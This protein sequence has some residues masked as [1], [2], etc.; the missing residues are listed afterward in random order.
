MIMSDRSTVELLLTAL[1]SSDF[2]PTE[3]REERLVRHIVDLYLNDQQFADARPSAAIAEPEMRL[4]QI[5]RTVMAGYADRPALGQRAVRFLNDPETGRT[6]LELL[7]R[8]ETVTYRE[9]CD[10][11]GAFANALTGDSEHSVRSGD[12]VC[13][14]GF[15]GVR[16]RDHRHGIDSAG[17]R[18]RSATAP[19]P[20]TQLRPIVAETEPVVIAAGADYLGDA[21]E[22]ILIGHTPVRLVV[23]DY[24][25]EADEQREAFDAALI[26]RDQGWDVDVLER[27][28]VLRRRLVKAGRKR[29]L[30]RGSRAGVSFAAW[31]GVGAAA[32]MV[33]ASRRA[34]PPSG[35][36][37]N[38]ASAAG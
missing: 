15:T 8:F 37:S 30:E 5:V 14:L 20:V 16:L 26:L 36:S 3:P 10:R 34:S 27:S 22:L 19:A 17:R 7:P 4:N 29:Y 12:R 18:L 13:I 33:R 24:H 9:L 6:S 31:A 32:R 21:V 28:P 2:M 25:P 23:F 11:V 38:A 35:R 1:K